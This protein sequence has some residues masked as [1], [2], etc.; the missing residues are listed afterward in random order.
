MDLLRIRDLGRGDVGR[1]IKP[2]NRMV[3]G[4]SKTVGRDHFANAGAGKAAWATNNEVFDWE[5]RNESNQDAIVAWR[6]FR[7]PRAI[8]SSRIRLISA[9]VSGWSIR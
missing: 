8:F 9:T 5:I 2:T 6:Q 4:P 3:R 7:F 1:G